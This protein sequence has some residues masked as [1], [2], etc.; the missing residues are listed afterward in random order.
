[1]SSTT[2]YDFTEVLAANWKD[3]YE[4]NLDI[5]DDNLH[6][7]VTGIVGEDVSQY[8]TAFLH[9]DGMWYRSYDR[10]L[11]ARYPIRGVF[12][13]DYNIGDAC[14]VIT[15]GPVTN[16]GWSL[17]IGKLAYVDVGNVGT[18]THLR[19]EDIIHPLGVAT[20]IDSLFLEGN[21]N[22][23]VPLGLS[24]LSSTST[25]TSS[26]TTTTA[27]TYPCISNEN[28]YYP[29]ELADT[30]YFGAVDSYFSNTS[31]MLYAGN[32]LGDSQN[33]FFVRF[34]DVDIPQGAII[35]NAY[36]SAI[37]YDDTGFGQ[38]NEV[39]ILY[40]CAHPLY[41]GAP[42]NISHVYSIP[43]IASSVAEGGIT[44]DIVD[45]TIYNSTDLTAMIQSLVNHDNWIENGYIVLFVTNNGTESGK[46]FTLNASHVSPYRSSLYIEYSYYPPIE[47]STSSTTT[48]SYSSTSTSPQTEYSG[49][50]YP[51]LPGDCGFYGDEGSFFYNGTG[52]VPVGY[53]PY[54][55]HG[56]FFRFQNVIVPQGVTI[57]NALMTLTGYDYDASRK[58]YGTKVVYDGYDHDFAPAPGNNPAVYA[59]QRTASAVSDFNIYPDIYHYS[60]YVSP[61][62]KSIVQ[63][64]VNREGWQSGNSIVFFVEDNGS[65]YN[66]GFVAY[67]YGQAF[68]QPSLYIE[69]SI[70][71]P[72][73]PSGTS[74]ST[75][76][77]TTSTSTISTTSSSTAST[78][79]T[80]LQTEFSDT[81]Y[82]VSCNDDGF[83][84][85][86][87]SFFYNTTPYLQ[88]GNCSNE[89]NNGAF[90]RFPNINIP[91]GVTITEAY[92]QC[93]GYNDYGRNYTYPVSIQY[94]GAD[95]D[96][97]SAPSSNA[98]VYSID[99][100]V[101]SVTDSDI[102]PDVDDG[103]VYTSPDLKTI[104][105]EIIN[106]DGWV[107][108][109]AILLF[110]ENNGTAYPY[111]F[112]ISSI[113]FN[114][115]T[116]K[117]SLFI[118]YSTI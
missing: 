87:G 73:D 60:Q 110:I 14:K 11:M 100:T 7:I 5:V 85:N 93:T 22:F 41:Q 4:D 37:G 6:T 76:T 72:P 21:L 40:E 29:E 81:F 26:T 30:G 31:Q 58:T 43:R 67:S 74:T 35:N 75:S 52:Y 103:Y 45:G 97:Q 113:D 42:S 78:T 51:A 44:P 70:A 96:N 57:T 88:I 24:S 92:I 23:E 16:P 27:S 50:Y 1:M 94:T 99:K 32:L 89:S 54:H 47:T 95:T 117:V 64:I 17:R 118:E 115:G 102:Y 84:G 80:C 36:F 104:I 59:A 10:C 101:S 77:S 8:D 90:I 66:C 2:N 46:G 107:S 28:T 15:E 68:L 86:E 9:P 63:E 38:T 62:L 108:G 13:D 71:Q 83:Y 49:T 65:D 53:G 25:T 61:D 39:S 112:V 105:Q 20:A 56:S 79:S 98:N 18:L 69:Y 114:G 34:W 109:N 12:Y 116:E 82:P 3:T 55:A 33:G 106:R 19:P 91:Q 48:S 111:G